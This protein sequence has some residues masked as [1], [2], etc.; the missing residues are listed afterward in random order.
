MR[1]RPRSAKRKR[2]PPRSAEHKRKMLQSAEHKRKAAAERRAQE[3]AAAERAAREQAAVA[4]QS[5][6]QA[7]P[8]D[9]GCVGERGA[10]SATTPSPDLVTGAGHRRPGAYAVQLNHSSRVSRIPGRRAWE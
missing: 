1:R 10:V 4:P 3:K 2:R 7:A 6:R 5:A 8:A 9:D